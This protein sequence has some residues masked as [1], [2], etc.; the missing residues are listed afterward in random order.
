MAHRNTLPID[1]ELEAYAVALDHVGWAR[2]HGW[3]PERITRAMG[4]QAHD[5]H[6]ATRLVARA[7]YAIRVEQLSAAKRARRG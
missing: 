6:G 3:T 5:W 7:W 1:L 4:R 2:E